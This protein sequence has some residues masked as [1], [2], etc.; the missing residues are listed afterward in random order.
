MLVRFHEDRLQSPSIT[1]PDPGDIA[2][3]S[4]DV[5]RIAEDHFA[6]V[7]FLNTCHGPIAERVN[8]VAFALSVGISVNAVAVVAFVSL[9]EVEHEKNGGGWPLY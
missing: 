8:F 4:P 3:D 2:A 9:Y 6:N 5:I 7:R 1:L